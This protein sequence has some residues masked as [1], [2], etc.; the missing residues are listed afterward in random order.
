[1]SISAMYVSAEH[2][3]FDFGN[4]Y[5]ACVS[6]I[7]TVVLVEGGEHPVLLTDGCLFF[8]LVFFPSITGLF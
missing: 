2:L 3:H 7:T 1:M 8:F 6:C 4:Y 5:H